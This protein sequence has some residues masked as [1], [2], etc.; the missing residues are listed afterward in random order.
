MSEAGR[1]GN[2]RFRIRRSASMWKSAA[3]LL[4]LAGPLPL[5]PALAEGTVRFELED[6][7]GLPDSIR[8]ATFDRRGNA[9]I[10]TYRQLYRMDLGKPIP[11]A[12][13]G[14]NDRLL[15]LAPGGERFAWLDSRKSSYGKFEVG[16]LDPSRPGTVIAELIPAEPPYG[17]GALSMGREGNLIVGATALEDPEGLQGAFRYTFWSSGG[18]LQG[19]T[20]VDGRRIRILDEGGE[21]VLLLGRSDVAAYRS[22]GTPIWAFNG[23]FRK[24]ALGRAGVV[25]LLNPARRINEVYLIRSGYI[26]KILKMQEPVY[27]LAI[28]PDGSL[29]AVATGAGKIVIVDLKSCGSQSCPQRELPRLPVAGTHYVTDVRFLDRESIV[30]GVIQAAW[31]GRFRRFHAGAVLVIKTTGERRFQQS[32]ELP[33]PATWSPSL[34]VTFGSPFFAAYTPN[35]AIFVE[36]DH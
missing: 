33:D 34:D 6:G 18:R 35:A 4:L 1:P 28:T 14:K 11:V 20:T 2:E 10:A 5:Q 23:Q 3:A 27:G 16:L 36:M 13:G 12:S 26:E 22:D 8:K 25:A 30:V 29:A 31:A 7:G 21:A 32:I 17:F 15:A 24:G 9:W 19:T